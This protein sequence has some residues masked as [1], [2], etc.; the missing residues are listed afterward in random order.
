MKVTQVVA[1]LRK[2]LIFGNVHD[3]AL[4][5]LAFSGTQGS[6]EA[7]ELIVQR[8]E[9]PG[10]AFVVL[11]GEVEA[12]TSELSPPIAGGPSTMIGELALLADRDATVNVTARTPCEILQIDRKLFGRVV[13]EFP[14]IATRLHSQ[15]LERLRVM[16]NDL[17]G[18]EAHLRLEPVSPSSRQIPPTPARGPKA[19]P[20]R[21]PRQ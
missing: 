12:Q 20:N 6:F 2:T 3:D 21:G 9:G 7:G 17:N 10:T 19:A 11:S 16:T 4:N 13:T 14:E 8:G 18:L 15:L 1:I 5:V